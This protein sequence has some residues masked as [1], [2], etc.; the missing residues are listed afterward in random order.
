MSW[1]KAGREKPCTLLTFPGRNSGEY[2]RCITQN[3][4]VKATLPNHPTRLYLIRHG[5]VEER[6]HRI[7]GGSRIDMELSDIG[8]RH[9]Q[10]LA[11]WFERGSLDAAYVSPM[12]RVHQTAAPLLQEHGLT[13]TVLADLREVDFGDWTGFRWHEIREKFG[14]VA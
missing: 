1:A 12:Q 3:I 14:V 13:S 2:T 5:E 4:P 11:E 6:Y 9:A 8:H 10:A 7:F